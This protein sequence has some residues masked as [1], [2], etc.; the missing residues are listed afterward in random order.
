MTGGNQNYGTRN[1]P[2]DFASYNSEIDNDSGT[3]HGVKYTCVLVDLNPKTLEFG[4]V[5]PLSD[6]K[7]LTFTTNTGLNSLT[8]SWTSADNN[9]PKFPASTSAGFM[10]LDGWSNKGYP[11]V[12]EF[13][14]TPYNPSGFNRN[15]LA[16][17]N[18]TVFMYPSKDTGSGGRIGYTAGSQGRVVGNACTP[19]TNTCKATITGLGG[20]GPYYLIRLVDY[21]D[22]SNISISGQAGS[23]FVNGQAM[24]DVTGKARDVLKRLQVRVPLN[25]SQTNSLPDFALEGQSVCKRLATAPNSTDSTTPLGCSDALNKP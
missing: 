2:S 22:K 24:I 18:F 19:S 7:Y 17:S 9:N 10:P 11:A 23:V 14:I 3:K 21:Y 1:L 6:N 25:S 16:N 20:T 13:S 12:I 5:D 15:S 4:A 8:V